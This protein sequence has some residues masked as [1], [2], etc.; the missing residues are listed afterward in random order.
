MPSCS[1]HRCSS[2]NAAHAGKGRVQV[3]GGP[4]H[5]EDYGIVFPANSLLRKQV[6]VVLLSLREDGSYGRIYDKWFGAK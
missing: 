2:I 3:V 6:N 5:K 4:F 1:M